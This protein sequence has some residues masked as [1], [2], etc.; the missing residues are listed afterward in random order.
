VRGGGC[1]EDVS[2]STD[3]G[4][5]GVN[6]YDFRVGKIFAQWFRSLIRGLWLRIVDDPDVAG[7]FFF[8]KINRIYETSWR[9]DLRV[10]IASSKT[11]DLPSDPCLQVTL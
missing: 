6:A 8:Q 7:V 9:G 2:S 3:L 4:K 11:I 5:A 10:H 1:G